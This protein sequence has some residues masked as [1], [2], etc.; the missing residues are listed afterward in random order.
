MLRSDRGQERVQL[1]GMRRAG[2]P[3]EQLRLTAC[4]AEIRADTRYLPYGREILCTLA[5]PA[6][7][8]AVAV[9]L[10]RA[11]GGHPPAGG[12]PPFGGFHTPAPPGPGPFLLTH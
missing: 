1:V 5:G 9:G 12:Q 4:G 10:G 7:N 8:L 2:A 3:V 11:G 6:V